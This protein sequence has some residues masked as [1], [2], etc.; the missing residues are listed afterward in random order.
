MD[1]ENKEN[2]LIFNYIN[3]LMQTMYVDTLNKIA[4]VGWANVALHKFETAKEIALD[5]LSKFD[6][7]SVISHRILLRIHTEQQEYSRVIE[8]FEENVTVQK[9][10]A[11]DVIYCN[12]MPYY[13]VSLCFEG[14]VEEGNQIMDTLMDKLKKN[15]DA[16]AYRW[17]A[18]KL[19]Y[20]DKDYQK[21][22]EFY[23]KSFLQSN[24]KYPPVQLEI[25]KCY[26]EMSEIEKAKMNL[27]EAWSTGKD[28]F[29]DL[30]SREH[31][32]LTERIESVTK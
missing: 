3:K 31:R 8:M 7:D 24:E 11:D 25:A 15:E 2:M 6:V 5:I 13:A 30:L 12:L 26:L 21:A 10:G 4:K 18:F 22:I 1:A 28:I 17:Y 29:A 20:L 9:C 32:L 16:E 14:R 23:E 27:D 19:Q